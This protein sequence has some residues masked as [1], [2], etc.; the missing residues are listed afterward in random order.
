MKKQKYNYE[1][2]SLAEIV[3]AYLSDNE[4]LVCLKGLHSLMVRELEKPLIKHVLKK[5]DNNQSKAADILGLNRNTLKKK[6]VELSLTHKR[7]AIDSRD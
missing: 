7:K 3:Q 2:C 1:H 5:T 4:D 6:M